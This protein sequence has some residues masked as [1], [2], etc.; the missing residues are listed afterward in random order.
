MKN[1]KIGIGYE[2]YRDFIN[3][4][5]YYVDKTLLIRDIAAKGGKVT[6]F[7]RPRRFG[8]TLALSMLRT[9]FEQESDRDGNLIDKRRY[10]EGKKIMDCDEKIL[11]MMGQYPVIKLSL[12]GA[13]QPD[14]Y[15]AF[16]SLENEIAG[17]FT[18]HGYL[19]NSESLSDGQKK[20]FRRFKKGLAL[21]MEKEDRFKSHA[22]RTAEFHAET[23]LYAE[24]L[25]VLSE[26]LKQHHGRKTIILIDEYDVPLENAYYTGFYDEMTGFIRSLF[27]AALKTNDDLEFAVITGCL[28]ISRESIFTG[29]NHLKVDSIRDRDFGDCFGFTQKETEAML[30]AYGLGGKVEEVR[31]WYDGYLFGDTEVY[32]PWSVVQYVDK[33]QSSPERFP[34]PYWANTSSNS[35]IKDMVEHS[36]E[37]VKEELNTLITGGTI[38]KRIHE[39]I[40]YGDIHESEDNLWN[41]LFFTG[42]MRKVS[43]RKKGDSIYVT[44]R[45]PNAEI[46]SIYKNQIMNWFER[47]VKKTE[48]KD[49]YD[50]VLRKDTEAIGKILTSLLKKTISTYDCAESFYHGF[51]LSMLIGLPDYTA[52]SNRES[53]NGRP[54]IIMYPENPTDPACIFELKARKKFN[55]MN[56]GL[57]EVFDQI[58]D[59]KYEEGILE[60]GYAGVVSFGIC[61]CKKSCIVGLAQ[62][63]GESKEKEKRRK[64]KKEEGKGQEMEGA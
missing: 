4:D 31:E 11:S 44:M 43:E 8:K 63:E 37:T 21:W 5:M 35:I 57:Q 41:F 15:R 61:F 64:E 27:E 38:E 29:L 14:F 46:R 40:T 49:F 16:I 56:S 6:L 32:N 30:C 55:E 25:R 50:A 48:R 58:R 47:V 17:E 39:D 59:Q 42:Y 9:F 33:H 62:G 51:L 18:R 53:G 3:N 22:E 20:I 60:E 13:K 45:L 26:C 7:A 36:D 12:K 1:K 23:G 52:R 34:E 2:D 28:R 10:F 24:S 19:Q 54:D